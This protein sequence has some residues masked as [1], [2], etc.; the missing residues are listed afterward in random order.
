MYF[1]PYYQVTPEMVA[2][3]DIFEDRVI[4]TRDDLTRNFVKLGY[5]L[6]EFKNKEYF[7]A[8]G[9]STFETWLRSP[10]VA[11]SAAVARNVIRI[12]NDIIPL[13][14]RQLGTSEEEAISLVTQAGVSKTTLSFPLI[15]LGFV[16]E[17]TQIIQDAP[18]L[19]YEDVRLKV[20]SLKMGKD[21]ELD[22]QFPAMFRATIRKGETFSRIKVDMLNGVTV[23]SCGQL[24]IRNIFLH[25]FTDRFGDLVRF[26]EDTSQ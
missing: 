4:Q 19:T 21:M 22:E 13:L 15:A 5:Y 26:E 2:A 11:I 12:K 23:E 20:K 16:D 9:Y 8:K 7:K 14:Q 1:D 17:V 25:R 3:A 10:E 24:T 18:Q 6:D